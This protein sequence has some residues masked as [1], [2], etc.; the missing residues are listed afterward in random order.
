MP[1]SDA[2]KARLI[3]SSANVPDLGLGPPPSLKT[4]L[5]IY[6]PEE[7]PTLEEIIQLVRDAG[8]EDATHDEIRAA[9]ARVRRLA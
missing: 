1:I 8:F 6:R 7:S 3:Q 9:W 2:D 4:L 5:K